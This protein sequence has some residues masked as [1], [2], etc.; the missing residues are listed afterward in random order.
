MERG[1]FSEAKV[2][3]ASKGVVCILVDC[4]WGKA[5]TDLSTKYKIRGYPTI[6]F[7]DKNGKVVQRASRRPEELASQFAKHAKS[8]Q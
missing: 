6:L 2:V 1:A 5:N 8:Y 4:N 3:A 7:V